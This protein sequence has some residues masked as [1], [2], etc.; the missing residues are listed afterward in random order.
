MLV[1]LACQ[2]FR[3]LEPLYLH[4]VT[5]YWGSLASM[6]NWEYMYRLSGAPHDIVNPNGLA[7]IIVSVIPFLFY[8]SGINKKVFF[9]SLFCM[10][11]FIWALM[12]TSSRSGFIALLA[13]IGFI[14]M[15]TRYKVIMLVMIILGAIVIAPL[16]SADQQD[17]YLS[18]TS[19]DTKNAGTAAGRVT[20]T[21]ESFKTAF[22]K[23]MVGHGLGTS[24]EA[25][26]NYTGRDQPVHN[27]YVEVAQELGII[28]LFIFLLYILSIIRELK[29]A[30]AKWNQSELLKPH[31]LQASW[32]ALRVFVFM[33]LIFS[34][35]SYGLSGY[36]WYL[37]PGLIVVL[38][39][40]QVQEDLSGVGVLPSDK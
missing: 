27:L 4:V 19:Q 12:L 1:F 24:R 40:I 9:L 6:A 37:I 11:L 25:N 14:V 30:G 7:F 28:G 3:I 8:Y 16:L 18:I 5:G 2:S 22:H 29:K 35:A 13:V 15:K 36:E 38:S 34:L 26:Y 21:I 20:R 39:R 17:R 32:Q 23:P 33:N 31:F 10:P